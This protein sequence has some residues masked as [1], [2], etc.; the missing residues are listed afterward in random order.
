MQNLDQL[1]SETNKPQYEYVMS[2]DPEN[3][4]MVEAF[5]NASVELFKN[6]AKGE[7]SGLVWTEYGAHI[8]MYTRDLS[9]FIYTGIIDAVDTIGLARADALFATLTAYGNRT[10]FDTL[11]DADPKRD[12]SK[13]QNNRINDYRSKHPITIINSEFKD[14]I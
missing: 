2:S 7:I 12:Y 6:R 4:K 11:V 9:D 8:I 1:N 5:T 14:F 10:L 13:Y 3:S